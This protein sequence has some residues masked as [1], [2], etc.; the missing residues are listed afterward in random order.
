MVLCNQRPGW[1]ERYG[2]NVNTTDFF[3]SVTALAAVTV[4]AIGMGSLPST[5]AGSTPFADRSFPLV[6]NDAGADGTATVEG[7]TLAALLGSFPSRDT[8]RPRADG[9]PECDWLTPLTV[10]P[11]AGNTAHV[12]LAR[13]H[14]APL[15]PLA[16]TVSVGSVHRYGHDQVK[17]THDC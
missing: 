3:L 6:A 9:F 5:I 17:G 10:A 13:V 1:G 14:L 16:P 8:Y 12:E 4:G 7:D 15:A 11:D 2:D